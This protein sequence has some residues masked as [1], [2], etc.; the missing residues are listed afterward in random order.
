M[1]KPTVKCPECNELASYKRTGPIK[2]GKGYYYYCVNCKVWIRV[3][4]GLVEK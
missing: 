3:T 2:G 4:Y 1:P